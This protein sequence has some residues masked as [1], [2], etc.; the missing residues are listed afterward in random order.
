MEEGSDHRNGEEVMVI[1]NI[2]VVKF[3]RTMPMYCNLFGEW[4]MSR[5]SLRWLQDSPWQLS[6]WWYHPL[7][8]EESWWR[9]LFI[10]MCMVSSAS[11]T[12]LHTPIWYLRRNI[13]FGAGDMIYG[14]C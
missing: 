11:P 9:N 7:W 4:A 14:W 1:G 3:I 8:D 2:T 12:E 5:K 6:S 10:S 13:H